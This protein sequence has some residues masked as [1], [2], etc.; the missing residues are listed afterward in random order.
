M[1][2]Y[3]APTSRTVIVD[4]ASLIAQSPKGIIL[5]DEEELEDM[6]EILGKDMIT[7]KNLWNEE[8]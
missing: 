6:T 3:I 8:W 5:D 7:S 1:K 4:M 2:K